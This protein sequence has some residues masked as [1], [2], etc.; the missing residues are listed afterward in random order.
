MCVPYKMTKE[1]MMAE[2]LDKEGATGHFL[3]PFGF[4]RSSVIP[5]LARA[6]RHLRHAH[7]QQASGLVPMRLARSSARSSRW[8]NKWIPIMQG[9]FPAA[10]VARCPESVRGHPR[11]YLAGRADA[12]AHERL[13]AISRPTAYALIPAGALTAGLTGPMFRT[14]LTLQHAA[15]TLRKPRRCE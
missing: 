1:R 15:P 9:P 7:F 12:T 14:G 2:C 4:C 10:L 11:W 13:T 3:S 6:A 5:P 8:Q